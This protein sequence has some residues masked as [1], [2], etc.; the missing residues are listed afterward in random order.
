[1]IAIHS[2]NSVSEYDQAYAEVAAQRPDG[3]PSCGV[4]GRMTGFGRYPRNKLL[5]ATPEALWRLG[6]GQGD[7]KFCG[8][9]WRRHH[10]S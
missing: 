6:P 5:E 8:Q 2:G 9:D 3:C 1:M 7:K 4:A 10:F